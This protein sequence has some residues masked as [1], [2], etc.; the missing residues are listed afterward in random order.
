MGLPSEVRVGGDQLGGEGLTV[1]P[2]KSVVIFSGLVEVKNG[3]AKIPLALPEFNGELRL[4][5]VAWSKTGLGKADK[6]MKVRDKAPSDLVMPRF[7]APGER[8]GVRRAGIV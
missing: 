3:R 2:T 1:V 6:K 7:L 5:A 8:A 4:M